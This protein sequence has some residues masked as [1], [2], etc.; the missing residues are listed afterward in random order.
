MDKFDYLREWVSL[1]EEQLRARF[2]ADSE[3]IVL[4]LLRDLADEDSQDVELNIG[5]F[6]ALIAE[7]HELMVIGSKEFG[8]S[9]LRSEDLVAQGNI[10][11]AIAELEDF[12]AWTPSQF[13]KAMAKSQIE[14]FQKGADRSGRK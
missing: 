14:R 7:L 13:F 9:L 1:D 5:T 6:P 3:R 10:Q 12:R 4:E 8:E 2:N 11:D